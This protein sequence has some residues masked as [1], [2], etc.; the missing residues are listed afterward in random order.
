MS[1]LR[2]G[3]TVYR[4]G[5]YSFLDLIGVSAA[6]VYH[7]SKPQRLVHSED[8]WANLFAGST[9]DAGFLINYGYFF[10]HA[11]LLCRIF[12]ENELRDFADHSFLSHP[13]ARGRII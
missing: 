13:P 10:S 1:V 5:F 8:F 12:G 7:Q 2:P 11:V 4:A 6:R 9:A 3:N